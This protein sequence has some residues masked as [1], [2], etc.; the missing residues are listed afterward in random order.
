MGFHSE[1][2]FKQ[3]SCCCT[4]GE[5]TGGYSRFSAGKA[6]SNAGV[7]QQGLLQALLQTLMQP[8]H[9]L[10]AAPCGTVDV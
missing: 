9:I 2:F 8:S 7:G 5:R 1:K 3:L 6:R 4:G 10:V